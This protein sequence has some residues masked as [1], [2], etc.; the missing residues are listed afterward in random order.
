L[1][2]VAC[3]FTTPGGSLGPDD[4]AQGGDGAIAN[5]DAGPGIDAAAMIDATPDAAGCP[6]SFVAIPNSGGSSR[7]LAFPKSSQLGALTT[8][9]SLN[10]HLARL[11]DQAEADALESY[12]G[13]TI[14]SS[15]GIY[16]V[17]GARDLLFR[18]LWHDLDFITLLSF[19]PWGQNEPSDVFLGGEDCIVLK[20]EQGAAVISAQECSSQHEFACECD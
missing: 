7:Y 19:L 8:C 1:F 9:S 20:S 16:R 5:G 10:T 13:S 15:T 12:I 3:G 2:L 4:A 17:V 18:N 6:A 11:D 14:S